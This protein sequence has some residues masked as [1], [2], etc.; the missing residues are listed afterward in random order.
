VVHTHSTH[1]T[2]LACLRRPLPAFH[3]MVAVAGGDRRALRALPPVRHEAL[4]QAVVQRHAR[5]RPRCW[6]RDACLIEM[7]TPRPGGGGLGDDETLAGQAEDLIMKVA[8]STPEIEAVAVR[9]VYLTG[10]RR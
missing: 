8:S 10:S 6:P 9:T 4:S 2:A 3:Y 1:A 5:P 7:A